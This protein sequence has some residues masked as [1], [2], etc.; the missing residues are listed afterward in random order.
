MARRKRGANEGSIFKLPDGRWRAMADLGYR[1]GKRWRKAIEATT[2]QKVQEKL[3]T[4]LRDRQLGLNVAP[5][6]QTVGQF[7]VRWLEIVKSNIAPSTYVSYEG[8]I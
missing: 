5:E 6:R 1:N 7:L 4:L 2:R 8:I 3:T